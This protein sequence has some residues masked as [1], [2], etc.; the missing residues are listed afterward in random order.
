MT[1]RVAALVLAGGASRRMT[2]RNKLLLPV[3][4][5]PIVGRV[6]DAAAASRARSVWVV[7]GFDADAVREALGDRPVRYVANAAWREGMASSLRAGAA[8]LL[9]A[10]EAGD[11]VDGALV[12]LG[13][14]PWVRSGDLDALIDAFDAEAGDPIC[15]PIHRGRRGHPVLFAARY[16]P[17]LC[18]LR[19][20]RGARELVDAHSDCVREVAVAHDGVLRD[21]DRPE[22]LC[23]TS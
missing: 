17:S 9:G 5:V 14:M 8:A 7:T 3:D 1:Q 11:G 6:A 23:R 20:D 18:A 10:A 13:D 15:I 12:C 19:G 16:L 4:G 2:P 21:I 22:D